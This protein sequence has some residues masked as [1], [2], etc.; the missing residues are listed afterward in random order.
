MPLRL[1]EDDLAHATLTIAVK[2]T[3][4]RP[5]MRQNFPD[6][7]ERIEYWEAHDLDFAPAHEALPQLR[8]LVD[9]LFERLLK[10]ME[11]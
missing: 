8:Q 10:E 6:W 9:S 2:E 3:E 7:E 1:Q 4:H 11:P 5:L